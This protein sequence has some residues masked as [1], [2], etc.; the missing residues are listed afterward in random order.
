V[1]TDLNAKG[2]VAGLPEFVRNRVQGAVDLILHCASSLA[3]DLGRLGAPE[4]ARRD[5][6]TITKATRHFV[7]LAAEVFSNPHAQNFQSRVRHDL[8][9]PLGQI[10]GYAELLLEDLKE[11]WRA[12]SEPVLQQV[13]QAAGR[14][15]ETVESMLAVPQ[16]EAAESH[17]GVVAGLSGIRPQPSPLREHGRV[18]AADDNEF[19]RQ[20]LQRWL[21]R[22]GHTAHMASDGAEVLAALA[23][24]NFDVILLDIIMPGMDGVQVLQRIRE[25]TEWQHIPVIVVS[26]LHEMDAVTR[27][28]ELGAEDY[29]T[30]PFQPALLQARIGTCLEKKRMRDREAVHLRQIE[31]ERGK[32]NALIHAILPDEVVNELQSTGMFLPQRHDE[33]AVL[34]ADIVH[35]SDYCERHSPEEVV[36]HLQR[37]VQAFETI[38]QRYEVQKIKTI[39]DAFMAAAGL[40]KPM[41]NAVENCV[42]CG[43]DMVHAAKQ[44]PPHWDLRVGIHSGSVVAGLLGSRQYLFDLWGA[45]VNAAARIEEQAASGSVTL[46]QAAWQRVS[47]I[48]RA[49]PLGVVCMKGVGKIALFRFVEFTNG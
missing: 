1:K 38:V 34:F 39:G 37:L 47:G 8:L 35:F 3:T 6:D 25:H 7:A 12:K 5:L 21:G 41:Q 20:I 43:L 36:S 42:R 32:F 22:L 30:R 10:T 15:R 19:N 44:L 27:C 45:T 17:D 46:S 28:I 14:L 13:H 11:P 33:V 16:P 26:A 18:L 24:E 2:S 31:E 29:I 4:S 48:G 40:L 9:T 49:E 23:T